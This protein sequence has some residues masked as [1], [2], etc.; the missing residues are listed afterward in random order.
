MRKVKMLVIITLALTILSACN[1]AVVSQPT[2]TPT[3]LPELQFTETTQAPT[4]EPA[5][6]PMVYEDKAANIQFSYPEGWTLAPDQVIGDRGSQAALLS[7]GSS[8]ESV[9][10][11]GSRIVLTTYQWDPKNDLIAFVAQRKTAWE[12]SGFTLLSEESVKLMDER[13]LVIFVVETVEK[14][15]VLFAFTNSGENYLQTAGKAT[16]NYA[17]RSWIPSSRFNKLHGSIITEPDPGS[18]FVNKTNIF[19]HIILR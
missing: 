9:A 19:P 8:L 6:F 10:E 15:Q 16:F 17:G 5:R 11:G 4:T 2:I 18:V 3:L 14:T 13:N 1:K 12:A 7:P